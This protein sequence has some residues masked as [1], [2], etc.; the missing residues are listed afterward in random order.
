[1]SVRK[2]TLPEM[3]VHQDHFDSFQD[4]QLAQDLASYNN[5]VQPIHDAVTNS[6]IVIQ[7]PASSGSQSPLKLGSPQSSPIPEV[8]E[9]FFDA[10]KIPPPDMSFPTDSP[11]K[12]ASYGPYYPALAPKPQKALF[13]TFPASH[14]D[15]ENHA[16]VE[17]ASNVGSVSHHQPK[18]SLGKRPS[19]SSSNNAA[20]DRAIK[21]SKTEDE[22][23]GPLPDPGQMPTLSDEGGKPPYSYAQLIGMAILRA[24]NRR[25]T[26]AQIYK[27]ISDTFAYYREA[28]TG[29]TN[30]IRHNLS[31]N[32]AFVKKERPKDDPGKG[33]YWAIADGMEMQFAKDGVKR[34]PIPPE[35]GHFE[36][37]NCDTMRSVHVPRNAF[38]FPPKQSRLLDASRFPKETE[39]SSDA[40]IPA[41]DPP[42][43]YDQ[44]ELPRKKPTQQNIADLH[45]SPPVEI[46]SSPPVARQAARPSSPMHPPSFKAP[47]GSGAGRKRRS[48]NFRD[49]GYY[50]GLESSVTR[51]A[52]AGPIPLTSEGEGDRK[53]A[54]Q[55]LA[56][57]EI[58]RMRSS[59]FDPSPA[60]NRQVFKKPAPAVT[61]TS[62]SPGLPSPYK[63]PDGTSPQSQLDFWPDS[64]TNAVSP[65]THLRRHRES[66]RDLVGTPGKD[67]FPELDVNLTPEFAIEDFERQSTRSSE[68]AKSDQKIAGTSDVPEFL[69]PRM[70]EIFSKP[71]STR[72]DLNYLTMFDPENPLHEYF[73]RGSPVARKLSAQ[74][75][76]LPSGEDDIRGCV[77]ARNRSK[78]RLGSPFNTPPKMLPPEESANQGESPRKKGPKLSGDP[79]VG[80]D[81]DQDCFGVSPNAFVNQPIL[82]PDK[83]AED[84]DLLRGFRSISA[85]SN[86]ENDSYVGLRPQLAGKR[87]LKPASGVFTKSKPVRPP[88]QNRSTNAS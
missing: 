6:H 36:A 20:R 43:Q 71:A 30:S 84:L 7:P 46:H 41:S 27:W 32:K 18:S 65:N 1:M 83:P 12:G 69:T 60:K 23:V 3:Q 59:S 37:L 62:S 33:N 78:S 39:L 77:A 68:T 34:R 4:F 50:S 63:L 11:T 82:S 55:G 54:R 14:M 80:F 49:S 28:E 29:W 56:Q 52:N 31:L 42:T 16:R 79:F 9:G 15:K 47:I 74:K 48:D 75:P 22:P 73:M 53:R 57:D 5:A 51:P 58:R 64:I 24:P 2:K 87:K 19:S 25:L 21:R 81:R 40:T 67:L 70:P 38:L 45:S 17:N 26:L 13:A 72:S 35:A 44:Q 8:K 66:V 61:L 88:L 85:T 86:K 10:V 76:Q